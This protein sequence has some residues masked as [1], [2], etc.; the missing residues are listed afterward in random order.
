MQESFNEPIFCFTSD[1]DW[2][3]ESMIDETIRVFTDNNIPLTPFVTHFSDAVKQNY[4]G[5]KA[6]NVGLH[7]NF[8]FDTTHGKNV[9]EIIEKSRTLWPSATSFRSHYYVDSLFITQKFH[10]AGFK[11]DSNAC[12][13]LQQDIT[14]QSLVTGLLR[15]PVFFEDIIYA[16]RVGCSDLTRL[17]QKLLTGGLKIFNF[18]PIHLCINTPH[19]KHYM[20]HKDEIYAQRNWGRFVYEGDGLRSVLFSIID[21]IRDS[22]FKMFYLDDLYHKFKLDHDA[23]GMSPF[24]TRKTMLEKPVT[25][26]SV[27]SEGSPR[28][29]NRLTSDEK[30][31]IVRK[32]YNE[33]DGKTRYATSPDFNLRELEIDFIAESIRKQELGDSARVL[34]VGCGNGFTL[35]RLAQTFKADFTGIDFSSAMIE[36]AEYLK[37]QFEDL[38]GTPSFRVGDARRI[39]D[40]DNHFDVVISERLL[41]NLPDKDTQREAIKEMHRVLKSDGLLILVEGT[42]NGLRRLNDLRTSVG[43]KAIPDASKKNVSSLKFEEEE[44]EDFLQKY[45]VILKRQHFG[46]Y[47]LISRVVHPLLVAP[48]PPRYDAKIN[49]IAR[50]VALIDQD[51]NQ[52]GHIV[53]YVLKAREVEI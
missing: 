16:D 41:L 52:L 10:D 37:K 9:D 36:G 46:T 27:W 47:Y 20:E 49:K 25:N 50:Q 8:V 5:N 24:F 44:I 43:L 3:P 40:T 32:I 29:Y 22:G 38:K 4:R 45:F 33:T 39:E 51:H 15:F 2:A 6:K 23:G 53:G 14:P 7:P 26:V 1:L 48:N 17:K 21:F 30:S 28:D 11:Y 13:F 12:L 19:I 18:H 42:R 31:E 35:L 34:D